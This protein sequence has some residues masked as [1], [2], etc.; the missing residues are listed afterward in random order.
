MS[1]RLFPWTL[2]LALRFVLSPKRERWT[3]F[4][5]F[6]ALLGVTIS[7]TA[8]TTVNA[9]M[10]GFKRVVYEKVLSLNPHLM[11]TYLPE[12]KDEVLRIIK[13]EL[14]EKEIVS[15]QEVSIIQG[16]LFKQGKSLGV[17]VKGVELNQ[18]SKEVAFRRFEYQGK[19]PP[20]V[21][22]IIVGT[23]LKQRLSLSLGEEL[24]LLTSEGIHTPFGF[25]PKVYSVW[26][27]GFFES[28]VYDY[29]L[30]LVFTPYSQLK[31][32]V[33]TIERVIEVK[34]QD[35]FLSSKLKDRLL[36][37]LG[38][39]AKVVDW[40]EL[41]RNLF[42]ALKLE[43]FGL[44]VVLSL[45]VGVSLF[46]V[47]SAMV[48]LVS[49]KRLD[50]GILR[51]LGAK[52]KEVERLFFFCGFILSIFGVIFGLALGSILCLILSK[53]PVIKLPEEVYPVEYLPISLEVAD[54]ILI[55]VVT[56]I[57]GVLSALYPARKASSLNPAEILRKEG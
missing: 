11:I 16:L 52:K 21:L 3:G 19:T 40:Q 22:P 23:R 4:I 7:V 14:P 32:K 50:L 20:D 53:Y 18:T 12:D 36:R 45:M 6:I 28:G 51:A 38:L 10:T 34:L 31:E 41:N 29:D 55:S 2:W 57:L 42:S 17:I 47:I 39:K 27:A 54:L 25:F 43:K 9:V 1:K 33:D 30:S 56:L 48:M 49:E 46:T 13:S 5:S 15:L 37:N 24:S 35:P 26:V 8:L 44:F